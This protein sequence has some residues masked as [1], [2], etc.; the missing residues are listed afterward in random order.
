[1]FTIDA[2]TALR[3][4]RE[5]DAAELHALTERDRAYL[6]EWLPWV[7]AVTSQS[8][9][10]AFLEV[11]VARREAG[12]GPQFAILRRG[13]IGGVVGF[14]TLDHFNGVG[15]IGYWLAK[16]LQGQGIMTNCCRF[17]VRYGFLTLD[18]QRIE[19]AAAAGNRRS[20]A[21][22]ERLGFKLEGIL[23]SR[24]NLNGTYV[25]HAMYSLLRRE[26]RD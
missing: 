9:T 5:T 10:L 15:E 1:M 8:D 22:P 4:L 11:V 19:I 25:D 3:P 26:L 12:L 24:E 14:R 16:P 6:R 13:A 20:R 21:V 2:E 17:V 23:R 7:D 18:L